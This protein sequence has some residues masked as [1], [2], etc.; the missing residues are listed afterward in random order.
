MINWIEGHSDLFKCLV[1]HDGAFS[2][3][4][5]FYGTDELW[6]QKSEFCPKDKIGCNPFDGKD[7][8]DGY[9]KNSPE[10]FVKFWKTPMLVIHGG[11]DYRVPLTEALSTFTALQLK[12]VP[13]KFL[14]F[15]ME[16]HWV[17]N[18]PNQIKWYQE[19][20]DWFGK[21]TKKTNFEE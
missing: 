15:P 18:P 14:F 19:L 12:G 1:N 10:R 8:R 11:K 21:Y 16:N 4:S 6:F 20:F 13:S 3:I 7:I 17:L 5:K 9:E 2:V